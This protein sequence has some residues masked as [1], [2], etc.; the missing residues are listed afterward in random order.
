MRRT[1]NTKAAFSEPSG[2]STGLSDWLQ[3]KLFGEVEVTGRHGGVSTAIGVPRPSKALLAWLLLNRGAPSQR[4]AIAFRLWCDEPE[5]TALANLRR[6]VHLLSRKLTDALPGKQWILADH[7]TISWNEAPPIDLDIDH[8]VRL[9]ELPASATEAAEIYRSELATDLGDE[10]LLPHRLRF[11]ERFVGLCLRGARFYFSSGDIANAIAVLTSCLRHDPW[12]ED[13]VRSLCLLRSKSGDRASAL[14]HF[15]SFR[16]KLAREV[17]VGPSYELVAAADS[18]RH[19]RPDDPFLAPEVRTVHAKPSNVGPP[20]IEPKLGSYSFRGRQQLL[21]EVIQEL[22]GKSSAHRMV[23]IAGESG[24]G[25]SRLAKEALE[26]IAQSGVGTWLAT[27]SRRFRRPYGPILDLLSEPSV[28]R[29]LAQS[30]NEAAELV[31]DITSSLKRS[32]VP[33]LSI[34]SAED[35]LSA[36][37][38]AI[39]TLT[40]KRKLVFAIDDFQW[41]DEATIDVLVALQKVSHCSSFVLIYRTDAGDPT[42][43]MADLKRLADHIIELE[44]LDREAVKAIA[45]ERLQGTEASSSLLESIA[46]AAQGNPLF[47]QELAQYT[48]VTH[49]NTRAVVDL[50]ASIGASIGRRLNEFTAHEV[51]VL[52]SAAAIGMRF[53]IT[54]LEK[55]AGAPSNDVKQTVNKA[56]D[57]NLL[58]HDTSDGSMRFAHAAF[59][60]ALFGGIPVDERAA[61]HARIARELV[62]DAI[63]NELLASLAYHWRAAGEIGNAYAAYVAA[64]DYARKLY[65]LQDALNFYDRADGLLHAGDHKSLEILLKRAETYFELGRVG[66]S[67]RMLDALLDRLELNGDENAEMRSAALLRVSACEWSVLRRRSS[68]IWAG[69]ALEAARKSAQCEAPRVQATVML[70]RAAVLR[71]DA[72]DAL[73]LLK[74]VSTTDPDLAVSVAGYRGLAFGMLGRRAEALESVIVPSAADIKSCTQVSVLTAFLQNKGIVTGWFGDLAA[75]RSSFEGAV[76][77]AHRSM[78]TMLESVALTGRGYVDFYGGDLRVA[79]TYYDSAAALAEKNP[80]VAK[81]YASAL[82]LRIAAA[83]EDRDLASQ[84]I[85]ERLFVMCEESDDVLFVNTMTGA[86]IDYAAVFGDFARAKRLLKSYLI[87]LKVAPGLW[88]VIPRI[89]EIGDEADIAYAIDLARHWN[90]R[91]D[92]LVA[93]AFEQILLSAQLRAQRSTKRAEEAALHAIKIFE[94]LAL[95]P[96][97]NAAKSLCKML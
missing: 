15:E 9:S 49:G 70:A 90:Y 68:T 32:E 4:E 66:E 23:T 24:I 13:I 27:C 79:R 47:A 91:D 61:A 87:R 77:V 35:F 54:L 34:T 21:Q 80:G 20:S 63:P 5:Q 57:R 56:R 42:L 73:G 86:L 76:T 41:V 64:G 14:Q 39:V 82:G 36:L 43:G 93:E 26:I 74:E 78:N 46:D 84:L 60:E 7:R 71:G 25:K 48:L 96:L 52:R 3:V 31:A 33:N 40:H 89:L 69:R 53:N 38:Q 62:R 8:F 67:R 44:P 10:W 58:V 22:T 1:I 85:N 29:D 12:R 19:G 92:N 45:Q 88:Y 94:D 95:R 50:P 2:G 37:T 75:A 28:K 17:G 65:A 59:H 81:I 6:H 30:G 83:M 16:E 51:N 11:H 18:I 55:V 72:D 97:A